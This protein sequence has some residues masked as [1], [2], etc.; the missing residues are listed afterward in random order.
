MYVCMYVCMYVFMYLLEPIFYCIYGVFRSLE[1]GAA[2]IP[3]YVFGGTDFFHNLSTDPR[4]K[5]ISALSRKL[6]MGLTLLGTVLSAGTA[7]IILIHTYIPTY[8]HTHIIL[9]HIYIRTYIHK[10]IQIPYTPRLT[11]VFG[12]PIHPP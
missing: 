12:D 1:T 6:K 9:I 4:F 10:Y 8:I 5:V 11:M 3:S 7:H 2:I